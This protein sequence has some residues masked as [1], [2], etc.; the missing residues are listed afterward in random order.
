MKKAFSVFG[1]LAV[2]VLAFLVA[3]TIPPRVAEAQSGTPGN[4]TFYHSNSI[5]ATATAQRVQTTRMRSG[6][7]HSWFF[8]NRSATETIYINAN[9]EQGYNG[10][11]VATDENMIVLQP[12]STMNFE[13]SLISRFSVIASGSAE[14]YWL[15]GCKG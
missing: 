1:A 10:D 2:A 3:S 14:L 13:E 4:A 9:S 5:T 11:A 15:C 8:Q 12:S 7:C 6:R